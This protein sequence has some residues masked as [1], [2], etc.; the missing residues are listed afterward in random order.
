[1]TLAHL[2]AIHEHVLSLLGIEDDEPEDVD[3]DDDPDYPGEDGAKSILAELKSL[4][5]LATA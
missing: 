1:V 5:E 4:V 3:E 2:N